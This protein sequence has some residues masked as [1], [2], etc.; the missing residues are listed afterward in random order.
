MFKQIVVALLA[1]A[2]ATAASIASRSL[3]SGT[4]TCGSNEYEASDLTAAI[5]AALDDLDSGNL[6][7]MSI[8]P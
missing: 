2:V 4:V 1:A 3:P 5:N 7:G 8:D 6:P